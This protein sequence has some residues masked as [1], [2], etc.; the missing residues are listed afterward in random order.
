MA[1]NR[2][3]TSQQITKPN[4]IKKVMNEF[5]KGTLNIG[6]SNKKVTDK[7]QAIAIEVWFK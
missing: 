5:K 6:K 2:S 1:I 7:N 3:N 4:K